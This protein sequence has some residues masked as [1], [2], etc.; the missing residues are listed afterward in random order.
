MNQLT[1]TNYDIVIIGAGI[2]GLTSGALFSRLGYKVCI[3][4]MDA[5]PGGYIAGFNRMDFRFDSAIHWLNQCGNDGLV[6]QAFRLIGTDFPKT[7]T[8]H[9]IKKIIS[10]DYSIDL[11]TDIESFQKKLITDFPEDKDGIEQFINNA[12]KI[13]KSFKKFRNINRNLSTMGA[14]EKASR[15]LKMLQ[16]VSP[17]IP[18]ISYSSDKV[19]LGLKKYFSNPKLLNLFKSE[20]DLLSC[21]IPIGW[22]YIQDYQL[23]PEGGSQTFA[24]WLEH[25]C[26]EC[27]ATIHYQSKV[28][29]ISTNNEFATGIEYIHKNESK[30]IS[31]KYI[32][33]ACDAHFLYDQ[34]LPKSKYSQ[35]FLAKI[36]QSEIYASAFTISIALD[37]SGESLGFDESM[38]FIADNNLSRKAYSDGNPQTCGIHIMSGSVRDKSLAPSGQGTLTIFIPSYFDQYNY[39]ETEQ[40]NNTFKRGE[41]YKENKK[42]V[43]SIIIERIEKK[44]N[45]D[46]QSHILYLDIATPITHY[47]YTGNRNGSMM[48]TRPGKKNMQAKVAQYKTPLKNVFQS[49]HWAELGGGIPIAVKAALNSTLLVLKRENK[50]AFKLLAG[51]M[52][53]TVTIETIE[54]TFF[55]VP[56]S[57]NWVRKPT[58]AEKT[59]KKR[60]NND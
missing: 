51:Y 28:Q 17:F 56:Y 29:S 50:P 49:G 35:H 15:G 58:P 19:E 55:L 43:A 13:G 10:D 27:H 2:S 26:Y 40:N 21:L 25:V 5:R 24:E 48:G 57:N 12:K 44:L 4:E 6:S 60:G 45:I 1:T 53:G 22:A 47:R 32:I 46:I 54:K 9:L 14:F 16:F 39:W 37:C 33:A 38:Y 31:C 7:K 20:P 30:N 42:Q 41:A 8:Q 11:T 18:H 34:L 59:A 23:P 36:E 3:L 52:D